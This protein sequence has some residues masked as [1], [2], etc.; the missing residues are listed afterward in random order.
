MRMNPGGRSHVDFITVTAEGTPLEDW[1][2]GIETIPVARTTSTTLSVSATPAIRS[3]RERIIGNAPFGLPSAAGD[4]SGYFVPVDSSYFYAL[5][6][7]AA[8]FVALLVVKS[9]FGGDRQ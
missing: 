5:G 9:I 3:F 7:G 1:F 4:V 2:G 6:G 8:L